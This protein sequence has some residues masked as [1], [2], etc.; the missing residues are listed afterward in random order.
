LNE[1]EI[2]SFYHQTGKEYHRNH[3]EIEPE[4][5]IENLRDKYFLTTVVG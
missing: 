1:N 2:C 4:I 3:Q 5:E